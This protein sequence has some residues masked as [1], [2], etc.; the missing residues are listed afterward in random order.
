MSE[1][2]AGR[3]ARYDPK[4]RRWREWRL[5]GAAQPYAVYVDD[6]DIVWLTDFGAER[7][8]AIRSGDP[9]LHPHPPARRR[10]RAAATRPAR[11]GLGRRVGS[12]PDRVHLALAADALELTDRDTVL[13][14]GATGVGSLAVQLAARAGATVVAPAPPEDETYLRDLGISELLPPT[15]TW[16]RP[17]EGHPDGFEA[18]STW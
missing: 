13:I 6:R 4:T 14:V 11:P 16:P 18:A 10:E 5:P 1:W 15:L 2:N 17:R 8:R 12:R 7:D 3:V 9:A